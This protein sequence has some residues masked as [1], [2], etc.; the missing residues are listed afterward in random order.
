MMIGERDSRMRQAIGVA[1]GPPRPV[2]MHD[3]RAPMTLRQARPSA[4]S[5]SLAPPPAGET[6]SPLLLFV[7]LIGSESLIIVAASVL[8]A[9]LGPAEQDGQV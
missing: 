1:S 9:V 2:V 3:R 6:W 4:T 5:I 8:L 7:V